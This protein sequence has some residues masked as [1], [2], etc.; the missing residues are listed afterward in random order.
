MTEMQKEPP[1][2]GEDWDCDYVQHPAPAI[3]IEDLCLTFTFPGTE[4]I[5]LC[6]HGAKKDVTES[7]M[8]DYIRSTLNCMF[9]DAIKLQVNAFKKGL[10]NV[11]S[12]SSLR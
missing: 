11:F 7:N 1:V 4:N 8:K 3:N 12:I 6:R 10:S 5:E 2:P 9:N